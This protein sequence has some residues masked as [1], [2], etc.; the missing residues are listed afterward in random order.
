M[1]AWVVGKVAAAVEETAVPA[2]V[3]A[4]GAVYWEAGL[5]VATVAAVKVRSQP[6]SQ[7]RTPPP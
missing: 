4:T 3:V 6:R 5:A 2:A 7:L 1:E